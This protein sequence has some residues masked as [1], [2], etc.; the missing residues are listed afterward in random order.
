MAEKRHRINGNPATETNRAPARDKRG[1]GNDRT[2]P[3]RFVFT[4]RICLGIAIFSAA[5]LVATVLMNAFDMRKVVLSLRPAPIDIT[6][7]APAL[8]EKKKKS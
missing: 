2:T 4:A 7:Q 1:R 8:E 3:F 5:L 6:P